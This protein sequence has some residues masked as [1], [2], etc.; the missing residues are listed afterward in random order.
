[1]NLF[2]FDSIKRKKILIQDVSDLIELYRFFGHN[3]Y[4]RKDPPPY[5]NKTKN[6]TKID[7]NIDIDFFAP[8]FTHN[9]QKKIGKNGIYCYAPVLF[10]FRDTGG[11]T[12]KL[13]TKRRKALEEMFG[14]ALVMKWEYGLCLDEEERE[15]EKTYYFLGEP[16]WLSEPILK[17]SPKAEGKQAHAMKIKRQIVHNLVKPM[18]DFCKDVVQAGKQ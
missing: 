7:A 12:R 8:Y 13:F 14:S 4:K 1:M 5:K 2:D 9:A 16:I 11:N 10:F 18:S 3:I 6:K 15:T 17:V